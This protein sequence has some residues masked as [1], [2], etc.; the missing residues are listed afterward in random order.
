VV[1]IDTG[2]CQHRSVPEPLADALASLRPL[3]LD[4]DA[5]VKAVA[6]GR[7][8]GAS[9]V[10]VRAELRPVDLTAGRRLQLV[11]TGDGAP[12]T[13][14]VATGAPAEQ[15]VD[16]LLAEPFGS[17]HVETRDRVVQLRVT[18]RGEAQVHTAAGAGAAPS[19]AH[20]RP[21]QH[22]VDPGDP[23]FAALGADAAKRRQVDAFLRQLAQVVRPAVEAAATAG[24]PLHVVDLGCG[25]AYLTFAAHRYLAGLPD[26]AA[27][28]VRTVGVDVRPA[29]AGRNTE[30]A[31]D[32][33]LQGLSFAAGT[34]EDADPGL[35]PVD[36]VLALHACDTATDDALARA[37]RWQ[38]PAVLAAPC[39]HHHVQAQLD[40]ARGSGHAPPH[41]YGALTRHSIL[42]ERFA[43]V[44]TDVMRAD[45]LRLL[46]YRVE[47]VE[48]VDSRHTPRNALL[49][50]VRTGAPPTPRRVAEY[51]DLVS[52]W[53]VSPK[54]GEL[55]APELAPVL[56]TRAEAPGDPRDVR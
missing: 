24:R 28:G 48:F 12:V 34:I 3:L 42:K 27:H 7:R 38:T 10:H 29:M 1:G 26:L 22:L 13:R 36:V 16:E 45:L 4:A 49:R 43:D 5:L 33:D 51:T 25:N 54:L 20:D 40:A 19:V 56:A 32:L 2:A 21:K 55:L 35:D 30:I 52:S 6:A 46:G 11:T 31:T 39:C 47:V 8:R 41:P 18:K 15:A 44:L 37:V 53:Q 17:W 14:N 23:M 9:P 50:G